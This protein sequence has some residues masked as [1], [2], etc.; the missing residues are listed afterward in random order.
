MVERRYGFICKIRTVERVRC[1][2]GCTCDECGQK[3]ERTVTSAGGQRC[4]KTTIF[5]LKIFL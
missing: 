4:G 1:V 5:P 2:L 3:I